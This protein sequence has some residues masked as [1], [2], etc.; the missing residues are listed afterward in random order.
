MLKTLDFEEPNVAQKGKSWYIEGTAFVTIDGIV[1]RVGFEFRNYYG[2]SKI[3]MC[4]LR[5]S[6]D[7]NAS[8]QA[9]RL[10]NKLFKKYSSRSEELRHSGVGRAMYARWFLKKENWRTILEKIQEK[11]GLAWRE[12]FEKV[13][14][15][16]KG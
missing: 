6:G 7:V 15:L 2:K 1:E 5:M 13:L 16:K 4:S 3:I 10:F 8:R 12:A 14:P 9:F 11:V